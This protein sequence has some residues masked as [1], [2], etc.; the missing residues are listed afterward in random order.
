[1]TIRTAAQPHT[2]NRMAALLRLAWVAPLAVTLASA[3]NVAF[4]YVVTR[5]LGA[6]LLF[7]AETPDTLMQLPAGDVVLFSVVFGSAASLVYAVTTQVARRPRRTYLIISGVVL[8]LSLIP[9]LAAPSPLITL[10]SR[11]TLASMHIIGAIAVV[12]TL[13]GLTGE[14]R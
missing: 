6:P 13:L 7:P 3:A 11:L 9:P 5:A 10:S 12:G 14:R 8:L 1:M 4:Y 2:V